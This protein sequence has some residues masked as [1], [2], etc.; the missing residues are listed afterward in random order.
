MWIIKNIKGGGEG[1]GSLNCAGWDAIIL[2]DLEG[3][4]SNTRLRS[5]DGC[6]LLASLAQGRK[7]IHYKM[8]EL[9]SAT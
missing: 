4:E 7:N 3:E 2:R 1:V 8:R 6:W 5:D 9:L